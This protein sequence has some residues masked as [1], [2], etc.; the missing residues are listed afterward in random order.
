MMD[1]NETTPGDKHVSYCLL[2]YVNI[3]CFIF[4]FLE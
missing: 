4:K 1:D 3:Q 2:M